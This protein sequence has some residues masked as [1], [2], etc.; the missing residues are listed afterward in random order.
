MF[1]VLPAIFFVSVACS[2]GQS[3]AASENILHSFDGGADGSFPASDVIYTKGE[4]IGATDTGGNS[5]CIANLGCGVLFKFTLRGGEAVIH[6]FE[7]G[8]Q[9]SLPAPNGV[10]DVGG[11]LYGTTCCGGPQNTGTAFKLTPD[12]VETRLHVFGTRPGDAASPYGT[13][14]DFKG[15]LFG[16]TLYG[17][18]YGKG[19]V[20][21]ITPNGAETVLHS[22]GGVGDGVGPSAGLIQ[23][24]GQLY[25]TTRD[26]G[27][28]NAGT[29]FSITPAGAETVLY[30]FKGGVDGSFP[31]AGLLGTGDGLLGTT[32]SGGSHKCG[33]AGCGTIFQVSFSGAESILHAFSGG[34]DDGELPQAGLVASGDSYYGTTLLGGMHG[35]CAGSGTSCGTVFQLTKT[36]AFSLIHRFPDQDSDGQYPVGNLATSGGVLYGL[37]LG[38]GTHGLGSLFSIAP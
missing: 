17:G 18:R 31:E 13:L 30:S 26:G 7:H 12:G 38:G 28:D 11:V 25:G 6:A 33:G 20:F 3:L 37:T 19:T 21:S 16:T 4:L 9:Q 10:V 8:T 14:N 24:H 23:A 35:S 2:P 15:R 34:P 5:G 32:Y 36:G 1:S 29:I 27:T 22:F